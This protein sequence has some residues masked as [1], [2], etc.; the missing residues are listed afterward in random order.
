M[1]QFAQLVSFAL[2]KQQVVVVS[3]AGERLE[4]PLGQLEFG[5]CALRLPARYRSIRCPMSDVRSPK[6]AVRRAG[7]LLLQFAQMAPP[8]GAV[9]SFR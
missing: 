7:H 9:A 4:V 1:F 3:T 6:S 2:T 5:A 8:A